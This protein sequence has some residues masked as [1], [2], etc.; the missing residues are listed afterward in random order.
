LQW[1][2]ALSLPR[3]YLF[4]RRRFSATDGSANPVAT[5]RNQVAERVGEPVLLGIRLVYDDWFE[6]ELRTFTNRFGTAAGRDLERAVEEAAIMLLELQMRWAVL[7]RK[8]C[9]LR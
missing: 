2:P 3:P 7:T 6:V 8:R 4:A 1:W 9:F 5:T